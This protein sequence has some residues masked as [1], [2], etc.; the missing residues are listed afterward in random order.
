MANGF[1][2][3]ANRFDPYK[4]FRFTLEWDGQEVLGVSKVG[5]IKRTTEVVK[6]RS[7]GENSYSHKSP[8]RTDY[9]PITLE[10]GLS[11]N[12]AFAAWALKVSNPEGDALMDLNGFRK[13]VT[14]NFKN[15]R[16]QTALRY[17]IFD[18]W[19]S[20][21]TGSPDLDSNTSVMA[22]ES[23]TLEYEFYTIENIEPDQSA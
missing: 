7:G 16:G 3:N 23:M 20:S 15:E 13:N 8:G 21:W 11:H 22:I 9:D 1:V 17:F 6:H 14:L 2:V 18:A 5:A 12:A 10:R 19:V 4:S